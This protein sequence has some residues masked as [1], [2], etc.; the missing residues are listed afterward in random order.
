MAA[1][2][3]RGTRRW[4]PLAGGRGLLIRFAAFK[5]LRTT[6]VKFKPAHAQLIFRASFLAAKLSDKLSIAD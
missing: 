1:V 5:T 2:Q 6:A 3:V 4:T